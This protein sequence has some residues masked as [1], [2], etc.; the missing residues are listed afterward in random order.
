MAVHLTPLLLAALPCAKVLPVL[1]LKPSV[2]PCRCACATCLVHGSM[3]GR[4]PRASV[5]LAKGSDGLGVSVRAKPP[6]AWATRTARLWRACAALA[7]DG[8]AQAE[9][10]S[11]RAA[12]AGSRQRQWRVCVAL[13]CILVLHASR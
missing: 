11:D 7:I 1:L 4:K 10:R 5:M 12:A 3:A 6:L 9:Q 8:E 2:L 13:G